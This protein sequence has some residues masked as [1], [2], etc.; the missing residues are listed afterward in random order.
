MSPE[1]VELVDRLQKMSG[2]SA[3]EVEGIIRD[4]G[5]MPPASNEMKNCELC[6]TVLE[7]RASGKSFRFIAHTPAFCAEVTKDRI[8]MLTHM[9]VEKTVEIEYE[10]R[11]FRHAIV[12]EKMLRDDDY[13]DAIERIDAVLKLE[14]LTDMPHAMRRDLIRDVLVAALGDLR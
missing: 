1:D 3:R 7:V 5:R 13:E 9:I 6:G 8:R 12:V 10:R 14:A 11:R 2:L 4:V